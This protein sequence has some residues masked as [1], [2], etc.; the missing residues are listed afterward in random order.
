MKLLWKLHKQNAAI[1]TATS[2]TYHTHL[3]HYE[4]CNQV[5]KDWFD[6]PRNNQRILGDKANMRCPIQQLL[7][8]G[9]RK[10]GRQ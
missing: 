5:E 8:N 9:N 4:E 7:V 6:N 3:V 2:R 10:I 1:D